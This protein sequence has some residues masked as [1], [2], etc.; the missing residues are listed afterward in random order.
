M[1]ALIDIVITVA[2]CITVIGCAVLT[3]SLLGSYIKTTIKNAKER[4]KEKRR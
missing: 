4:R 2:W 3:L 1:L